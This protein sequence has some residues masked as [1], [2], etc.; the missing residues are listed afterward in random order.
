MTT[1][2]AVVARLPLIERHGWTHDNPSFGRVPEFGRPVIT[3]ACPAIVAPELHTPAGPSPRPPRN[4]TGAG[5]LQVGAEP[6]RL[7][8]NENGWQ[9]SGWFTHPATLDPA[10]AAL[11]DPAKTYQLTA[12]G[13]EALV[14]VAV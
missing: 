11:L 12:D 8:H 14:T 9:V 13:T 7:S 4:P 6:V 1:P 2:A 5:P 10:F 3:R